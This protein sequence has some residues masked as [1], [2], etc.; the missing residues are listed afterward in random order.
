MLRRF[1]LNFAIFSML[2]D[3]LSV[4]ICLW[5]SVVVRPY[6]NTLWFVKNVEAGSVAPYQLFIL[7]PLMWVIIFSS[8][9]IYDGRK[10]LRA[11]DE[12]AALALANVI[13]SISAAGILYFSY[14]DVSRALFVVFV[15]SVF[16]VCLAWRVLARIYFRKRPESITSTRRLLVVG[17]GPLGQ[18]VASQI[19]SS[20][21]ENL[22]LVG[23]VGDAYGDQNDVT[24]LGHLSDLSLL[25]GEYSVTDVVI[26]LPYSEYHKM[27]E[28]VS[29]L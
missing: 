15:A 26:A 4:A 1:S 25:I 3:G 20:L 17:S 16:L 24:I 13:A 22:R 6:M 11:A 23:F 28:I 18:S 9:S 29:C 8:L 10:F 12:L 7:F 19:R 5:F 2:L 21:S 27:S 14:R